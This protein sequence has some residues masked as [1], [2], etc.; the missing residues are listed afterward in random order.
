MSSRSVG[1]PGS[2]SGA[3]AGIRGAGAP[4]VSGEA[5]SDSIGCE[6]EYAV[7]VRVSPAVQRDLPRSESVMQPLKAIDPK[8]RS[9]TLRADVAGERAAEDGELRDPSSGWRNRVFHRD[10]ALR[11]G[12]GRSNAPK[13]ARS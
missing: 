11:A 1:A 4:S 5:P 7:L 2:N 12:C 8:R 13:I 9:T 3:A 6:F 10:F